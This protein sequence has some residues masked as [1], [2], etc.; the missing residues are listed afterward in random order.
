MPGQL[1][2]TKNVVFEDR[3]VGAPRSR[4]LPDA[5]PSRAYAK[6]WEWVA[7]PRSAIGGAR[8]RGGSV[9]CRGGVRGRSEPSEL[10][11]LPLLANSCSF[12]HGLR[13]LDPPTCP[14][15]MPL[16]ARRARGQQTPAT[17]DRG[18]A[19][20]RAGFWHG[21]RITRQSATA[22]PAMS[23]NPPNPLSGIAGGRRARIAVAILLS[24]R[25][26]SGWQP[27]AGGS[28]LSKEKR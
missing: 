22:T 10:Y 16:R 15:A 28:A 23:L 14:P 27:D 26:W 9:A 17:T 3:G 13:P 25:R 19:E 1:I 5:L 6:A 20:R 11:V 21:C 4:A 8:R 7:R 18:Q 24:C 12:L 2:G